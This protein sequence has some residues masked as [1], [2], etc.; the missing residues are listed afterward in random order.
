VGHTVIQVPVPGLELL[1]RRHVLAANPG[2]SVPDDMTGC[3]HITLLGP[4][5]DRQDVDV[6]LLS[7][8]EELLAPFSAFTFEL[9][10]VDRFPSG[11]IYL[12]PNPSDPFERLTETLAAAFPDWPPYGGAFDD[13]VPHMSIGESLPKSDVDSL[14]ERLPIVATADEVTLTWWSHDTIATLATFPLLQR[15]AKY[16]SRSS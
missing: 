8:L 3:A 1:V 7:A 16:S 15:P 5:V 2:V 13:V 14:E 9:S 10:H 4:F 6:E 12:A 11:L